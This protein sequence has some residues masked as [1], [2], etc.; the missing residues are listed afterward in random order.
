MNRFRLY[1]QPRALDD[2]A[3]IWMKASNRAAVN[4]SIDFLEAQLAENPA[5]WGR[6]LSEG[7]YQIAIQ[8]VRLFFTL[9]VNQLIVKVLHAH[10][11]PPN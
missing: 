6:E 5:V 3:D 4:L 10:R 2:L 8:P 7:L 9:D 11:W 1:W